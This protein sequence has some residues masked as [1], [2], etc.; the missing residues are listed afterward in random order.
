MI[1]TFYYLIDL[2]INYLKFKFFY[3]LLFLLLYYGTLN[4][5][6]GITF[7]IFPFSGL[8]HA[9]FG[10]I[11][12][13]FPQFFYSLIRRSFLRVV[14]FRSLLLLLLFL[15]EFSGTFFQTNK[16]KSEIKEKERTTWLQWRLLQWPNKQ[17]NCDKMETSTLKEIDLEP[18]L[19]LTLKYF[20]L[21]LSS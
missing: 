5:A 8:F 1:H 15:L 6:G 12:I 14:T 7:P 16:Q 20:L 21:F 3:L 9:F 17:S 19:M 4:K 18:P 11:L 13:L 2:D 10:S